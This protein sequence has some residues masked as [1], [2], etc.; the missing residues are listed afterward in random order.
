[1]GYWARHMTLGVRAREGAWHATATFPGGS[2]DTVAMLEALRRL[3][4]GRPKT[5][6]VL[7]DVTLHDLTNNASTTLPLFSHEQ[8][9]VAMS[10]AMDRIN[11][12]YG[13]NT[14]YLGS[15]HNARRSAYG[16]I[17]FRSIPDLKFHDTVRER[18]RDAPT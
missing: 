18:Q 4:A 1:M 9:R 13:S 7:V 6:P 15:M 2:Q 10:K 14:V 8:Q 16:G 5:V 17:A 3:W 12:R 11:D